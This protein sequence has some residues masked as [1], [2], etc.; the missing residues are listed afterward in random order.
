MKETVIVGAV[1]TAIGDFEGALK[2]T[3][4]LEL[5]KTVILEAIRRAGIKKEDV[6]EVIFGNVLPSGLGQNPARQAMLLAKLSVDTAALTIN[7]V[8]ASGLKALALA[9]QAIKADES[10]IIVAGGMENMYL[11]PY[12][13]PKARSGYRLWDGKLVDVMVHDGLWDILSD[14]HMGALTE[15]VAD[16]YEISRQEQDRF[17][18]SSYRKA[19]QAIAAGAFKAEIVPIELSQ[20]KGPPIIVDT[21]EAAQRDTSLEA[22]AK[23]PPVFREKGT[24]TAGNSSKLSVGAAALVVMSKEKALKLGLKPLARIVGHATAGIDVTIP[25]AAPINSIPK[26]LKKVG[27]Q[28]K[29]I[30]LHE[31]N[32]AFAASTLAVIKVVKIDEE[33]V[34]LKGGAIALGHPIGCSGARVI[35]TML[36]VLQDRKAKLGMASV[37]LGGAEA[38]SMIVERL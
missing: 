14:T 23:L 7:K 30:D 17:S 28:E 38:V 35:V 20:R 2:D 16:R 10:D 13:L 27:L 34:N 12:Y 19:R 25:T 22:L 9:D 29:E 18:L 32:E 8:C 24:I 33:K 11:A 3:S 37:C 5:G 4:A 6:N 36:G 26:L 1:R 15:N 21:D 31:I